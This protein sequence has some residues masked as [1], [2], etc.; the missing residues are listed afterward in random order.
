MQTT[1][2]NIIKFSKRN[3]ISFLHNE[4][5]YLR[6]YVI[7]RNFE[8][9]YIVAFFK[10]SYKCKVTILYVQY[11]ITKCILLFEGSVEEAD[12]FRMFLSWI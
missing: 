9:A 4:W 5:Q 1:W 11:L 7:H 8:V 6:I 3:K 12:G 10:F 2:E